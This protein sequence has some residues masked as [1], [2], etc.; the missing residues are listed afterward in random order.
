MINEVY[1]LNFKFCLIQVLKFIQYSVFIAKF[2]T[3]QLVIKNE[4]YAQMCLFRIN[5][6]KDI[7]FVFENFVV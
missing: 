6:I 1:W 2:K 7:Y 4:Q 5:K 3:G